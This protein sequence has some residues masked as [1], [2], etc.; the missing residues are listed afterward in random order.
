MQYTIEARELTSEYAHRPNDD[1]ELRRTTIEAKDADGAISEF[2]RQHQSELV[3]FIRPAN[4]RESIATVKKED[5][6]YLV[7]VYT[8]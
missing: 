1:V 4:G 2:V 6:V 7:R 3:S 8:A 5:V